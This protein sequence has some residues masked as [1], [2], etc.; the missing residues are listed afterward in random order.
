MTPFVPGT[1]PVAMRAQVAQLIAPVDSFTKLH[2]VQDKASKKPVPFN[3][4]PMQEKIFKAVEAGHNRIACIKARQVTCTTGCKMVL[5][6]MAY[7]H[8]H[9]AMCAI[10]SMREDSAVALLD[11]NRRWLL[12]PPE[13]LRRPLRTSS[14]SVIQYDDTGASLRAF[15][16][17]SQT[18]IRSFDPIA[19]LVSEAAYA[20]DLEETLA[21]A[22]AAVGEGLLIIE[23]TVKNPGDHFANIIRDAPDN[24][25]HIISMWWWEHPTYFDPAN[26]F[27]V[28]EFEADLSDGERDLQQRYHLSL[29]QL[30]WRRRKVLSIGEYKFR[31][32]YPGCLDDCFL[33]RK[34]GYFGDELMEDIHQLTFDALGDTAGRELESPQASDRYVVGVDI[35]GG[36]GG[37]WSVM[38]V[39]SIA[40][41]QPVYMERSNTVTPADWA[42]RVIHVASRYNN[43][44]VLAEGN[45]HGHAFLLEM[46][47]CR[48]R[49]LWVNPKGGKP[50]TTTLQSKLDAF[51]SL[52]EALQI[53]K[54]MDHTTWME[55]RALTIPAG[56]V[57]PEAPKGMHDD[58]AMALALA[59]RAMRDVPSSWRTEALHS[60]RDRVTELINRSR[61]RKIRAKALPF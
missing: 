27:D 45:N 24:G 37:D 11:D 12:D 5:H 53:I 26:T 1:V 49:N 30:H 59:Y 22:D 10:I 19:A 13:L 40:T 23:S 29:G 56:K 31:R 55:L 4:M 38:Q 43:A 6:H 52:R 35:G 28:D 18:G 34:G 15:T 36:V 25:W 60:G 33:S 50:W 16:S 39:V 21:Q 42:H 8:H 14:A 61:A 7:T 57:A 41:M 17:R 2:K 47:H 44:I 51:D 20:P 32:E 54:V 48:Y 9:A 3:P 58:C 46:H